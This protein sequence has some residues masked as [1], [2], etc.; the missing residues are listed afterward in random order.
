MEKIT[1]LEGSPFHAGER[2]V[3]E[4]LGVRD[5]EDWARKVVRPFLPEQHREFH[6]SLPFLVAAAMDDQGRPWA[7]LLTGPDGFVTSPDPQ[8]LVMDGVSLDGDPLSGA[9]SSGKHLGLLGIEL[10]DRRRNRI[11]GRVRV[12]EDDR[13]IFDVDQSFGNCPQY[14]RER[15]WTRIENHTAGS[16]ELFES[17]TAEQR[18]WIVRADTFFIASG[19]IGDGDSPAFGMDASH[20]GGEPGFVQVIDDKRIRFPDFAGNN[21]YNT[22]GNIVRNPKVGFLF[23]DFP[24]GSLLH[25]TGRASID[26]ESEAVAK[27]PGARRIVTFEIDEIRER[28]SAVPLRWEESADFVRSLRLVEKVRESEEIT[29]FVFEARDGAPLPMFEAGQYLPIELEVPG[30][31][32]P[33]SRTYSLSGPP[34]TERYRISVNREPKGIASRH[35]HDRVAVGA[36]IDARHPAGEDLMLP[37][38]QCPVAL[39]SAGVGI[40]PM[41]SLLHELAEEGGERPVWFIHGTR[42]G[43]R[44]VLSKETSDLAARRPS[45]SLHVAYSSPGDDDTLGKDFDSEG[46]IDGQLVTALVDAPDAHYLLCGPTGFMAGIQDALERNG[47]PPEN[48][49]TESFG[50]KG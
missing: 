5:I 20:R 2:E 25:L 48:I 31:E 1:T 4:R 16:N 15:E 14:I 27:I 30:I 47:V 9:L 46:R 24:T 33:V 41:M 19:Y 40:T 10:A 37:C 23:V 49:H 17:L 8:S 36:I 50:P 29:S 28:R 12:G 13:L 34:S 32:G 7:T 35:L 3:Q 11:N 38:A 6:T 42:D 39:I 18:D 21:H 44:H 45:I 43:A 26:W 22:L